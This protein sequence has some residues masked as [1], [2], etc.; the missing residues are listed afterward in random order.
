M[1]SSYHYGLEGEKAAIAYMKTL[2]F[3][4]VKQRY[5]TPYGEIDL[6]MEREDLLVFLEVKARKYNREQHYITKRQAARCCQAA[7][8]FLAEYPAFHKHQ[9]RFDFIAL[10]GL[11]KGDRYDINHIEN[12]WCVESID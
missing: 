3:K 1:S 5:K 6:I 4:C 12:A 9:M 11:Q 8:L 7:Q 10:I 2:G